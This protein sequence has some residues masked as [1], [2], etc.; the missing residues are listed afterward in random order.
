MRCIFFFFFTRGTHLLGL[1]GCLHPSQLHY[2]DVTNPLLWCF[3]F[4]VFLSHTCISLMCYKETDHL[5][6]WLGLKCCDGMTD[7]ALRP[8]IIVSSKS[9]PTCSAS[10]LP[11][12]WSLK[13][14]C[15]IPQFQPFLLGYFYYAFISFI[16]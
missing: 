12:V 7:P 3:F 8:S 11:S 6:S 5:K 15:F 2:F 14:A 9:F 13:R 1:R 10:D 4:A 16:L